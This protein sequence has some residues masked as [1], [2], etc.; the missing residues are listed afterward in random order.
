[1]NILN[2][3]GG[4]TRGSQEIKLKNRSGDRYKT[5][6]TTME[7][8]QLVKLMNKKMNGLS[9]EEKLIEEEKVRS[10][11]EE[12]RKDF[13]IWKNTD[14]VSAYK[15]EKVVLDNHVIIQVYYYNSAPKSSLLIIDEEASS[16]FLKVLPVAKVLASSS[17]NLAPGDIVKIPSI[18]GKTVESKE[19]KEWQ[20]AKR[21]Q[22]SIVLDWPEPP[23][24]TGKLNDWSQYIYQLD[25]FVDSGVTDQYVFCIPDRYI[26]TKIN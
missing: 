23:K 15:N 13:E 11:I 2:S 10:K 24:Y 7:G 22:P 4:T 26:Q 20:M 6:E 12:A 1:M 16:S 17:P 18:Y 8:E 9:E 19:Y 5:A 14:H 25:P 3:K 21:E